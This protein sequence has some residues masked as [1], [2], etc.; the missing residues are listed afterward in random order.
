MKL[1]KRNR[2][3][4]PAWNYLRRARK[5]S[6]Q[7]FDGVHVPECLTSASL[8]RGYLMVRDGVVIGT[9]HKGD[10]VVIGE[11]GK[12]RL[13]HEAEFNSKYELITTSELTQNL[14]VSV[15][16][17]AQITEPPEG[18]RKVADLD[19]C[20]AVRTLAGGSKLLINTSEWAQVYIL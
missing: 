9:L 18:A 2:P 10:W 4:T 5:A 14:E 20:S 12:I 15:V 16:Y 19:C 17:Y 11:D 6:C 8:I 3:T 1:N 13:M 7:Q